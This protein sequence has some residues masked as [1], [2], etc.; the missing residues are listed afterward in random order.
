MREILFRGKRLDNGEWITGDLRHWNKEKVGIHH[1]ALHRTLRV[2][3][4]TVGQY[5]GLTDKNGKKVFEGDI[6]LSS[7]CNGMAT[8]VVKYG[9]FEPKTIY[10]LMERYVFATRPKAKIY[11]LFAESTNYDEEVLITN[12]SHLIKVI[13]NIHDNPELMEG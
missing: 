4:A 1:E 8:T 9:E 10:D 13:G 3:P 11:G 2:D 6:I 7:S 12:C 5:T